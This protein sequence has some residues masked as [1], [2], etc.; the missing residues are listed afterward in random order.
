MYISKSCYHY[1]LHPT[2][3]GTRFV[4]PTPKGSC[5]AVSANTCIVTKQEG[6]KNGE[7]LGGRS[8]DAPKSSDSIIWVFKYS[9][10]IKF[11]NNLISEQHHWIQ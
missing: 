10:S 2:S 3:F 8:K 6:A 1:V 5:W 9:S 11:F 4:A 7:I